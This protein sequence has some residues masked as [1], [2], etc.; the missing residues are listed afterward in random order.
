[1][2]AAH[3]TSAAL[4]PTAAPITDAVSYMPREAAGA[5]AARLRDLHFASVGDL[6]RAPYAPHPVAIL[7]DVLR[8]VR[9]EL[10]AVAACA[11]DGAQPG[12]LLTERLDAAQVALLIT[13]AT[14]K[15]AIAAEDY[16]ATTDRESGSALRAEKRMLSALDAA[17]FSASAPTGE[18]GAVDP[19]GLSH[20]L[21]RAAT[22][23]T[24]TAA[25][26]ATHDA[27]GAARRRHRLLECQAELLR[28]FVE[29][30]GHAGAWQSSVLALRDLQALRETMAHHCAEAAS[31]APATPE[32][33]LSAVSLHH[34]DDGSRAFALWR[35]DKATAAATTVLPG[36]TLTAVMR[37]CAKG[38]QFHV[39]H[40]LFRQL[41]E[42]AALAGGAG[43]HLSSF[44]DSAAL[45]GLAG[46]VSTAAELTQF[47]ALFAL[48]QSVLS[49][50]TVTV[51]L[52]TS[53]MEA[54]AR[55]VDEPG[56]L[57]IAL[58]MYR[59]LKD[60]GVSRSPAAYS[61]LMAV[62]ASVGEP[63]QA[64]AMFHEARAEC[65]HAA[66]DA[67]IYSSLLAAYI[68]GGFAA[69]AK[70]TFDVLIESGAPMTR[71]GFH[72]VL[73]ACDSL[74]EANGITAVMEGADYDIPATPATHAHVVNAVSLYPHFD[75]P[76]MLLFA[77]D[78]H[79][80][81]QLLVNDAVA[82][83]GASDGADGDAAALGGGDAAGN[84][85]LRE[86]GYLRAMERLLL[87]ART[88][89]EAV[90]ALVSERRTDDDGA[91]GDSADRAATEERQ[92]RGLLRPLVGVVQRSMTT[93]TTDPA[94]SLFSS[95][96]WD[97]L[98]GAAPASRKHVAEA[99]TLS[100][101]VPTRLPQHCVCAVVAPDVLCSGAFE[102]LH[103]VA[104]HF[105]S[106]LL[107]Y[108][109]LAFFRR[110]V[111]RA[112]Q[113]PHAAVGLRRS[114]EGSGMNPTTKRPRADAGINDDEADDHAWFYGEADVPVEARRRR[115]AAA[116][117]SLSRLL[118]EYK[119]CIHVGSLA[120]EMAASR[121]LRRYDV[122][123][124]RWD[125]RAAFLGAAL[126]T[127]GLGG[128]KTAVAHRD[129]V[130]NAAASL[131]LTPIYADA[132][133]AM[134][135]VSR[136]SKLLSLVNGHAV[137]RKHRREA[138]QSAQV[139]ATRREQEASGVN[140]FGL[141]PPKVRPIVSAPVA[142]EDSDDDGV[143]TPT[144]V[145]KDKRQKPPRREHVRP[146]PPRSVRGYNPDHWPAWLLRPEA[147][148]RVPPADTPAVRQPEVAAAPADAFD[149]FF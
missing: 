77:A 36:A 70:K 102:A 85:M 89:N 76:D 108:A 81:V 40:M 37:A 126:V 103:P 67:P 21:L 138:R 78:R 29:L 91:D 16:A 15:M 57:D 105:S 122:P 107:P 42:G 145:R 6:L 5:Y 39:A 120:E 30:C 114:G 106:I 62:C 148:G 13:A 149:V 49:H 147:T 8:L 92:W 44:I 1:V 64:F 133:A 7:L 136:D 79:A 60:A 135:V 98:A 115:R 31:A 127:P 131:Q 139:A 99:L 96:V 63:T 52:Y 26:T 116:V 123:L 45:E 110:A 46:C 66:L 24:P 118:L 25:G 48:S 58:A 95:D 27:F 88:P 90:A 74:E 100:P 47:R 112:M 143:V 125:A 83:S 111:E 50:V 43:D 73:S 59:G 84:A 121:V 28:G 3:V 140:P 144:A 93:A 128:A 17:L 117:T 141:V 22:P 54:C 14:R 4:A 82:R 86:V 56:R 75:G 51:P 97:Q 104:G 10:E 61:A 18:G 137:L 87:R 20:A 94:A 12:G 72:A 41:V 80:A 53:V 142:T 119:G 68:N 32:A 34:D 134:I 23:T 113:M 55:C 33:G 130:G 146:P 2:S 101:Q 38:R 132:D 129:A 71:D 19:H 9:G 69:D 124:Q 65:G 109:S 35:L 11:G